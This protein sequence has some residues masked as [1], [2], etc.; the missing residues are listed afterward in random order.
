MSFVCTVAPLMNLLPEL[1]PPMQ[2]RQELGQKRS[3]S[4]VLSRAFL[5][6]FFVHLAARQELNLCKP[7]GAV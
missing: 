3:N 6:M 7:L 4:T 5:N 2:Q 1:L